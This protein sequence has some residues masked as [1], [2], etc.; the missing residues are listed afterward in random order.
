MILVSYRDRGTD[1]AWRAGIA[2]EGAVVDVAA[3]LRGSDDTFE[4]GDFSVRGLLEQGRPYLEEVF[5]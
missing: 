2:H 1:A 3:R 5:A 4:Q